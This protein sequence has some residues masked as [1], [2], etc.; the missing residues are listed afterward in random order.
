MVGGNVQVRKIAPPAAGYAY[1]RA[2]LLRVVQHEHGAAALPAF[3]SAQE[4][5]CS[6][7]DDDDVFF[8]G[9]R[10]ILKRA[11]SHEVARMNKAFESSIW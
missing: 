10:S 9:G 5:R 3:D 11:F 7:A 4:P 6:R 1:L 2:R 8:G